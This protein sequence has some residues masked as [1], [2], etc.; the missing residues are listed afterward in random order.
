MDII[1]I[2]TQGCLFVTCTYLL[3]YFYANG[4]VLF[5]M[6][7]IQIQ[8]NIAVTLLW[9]C[10]G[11]PTNMLSLL[12]LVTNARSVQ[13]LIYAGIYMYATKCGAYGSRTQ[14]SEIYST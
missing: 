14:N 1:I 8:F 12:E 7:C 3:L 13:S 2:I 5:P 6:V 9:Y 10:T 11:I 4:F